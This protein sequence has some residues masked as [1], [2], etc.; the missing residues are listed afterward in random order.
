MSILLSGDYGIDISLKN[1]EN[2]KQISGSRIA[3]EAAM[4]PSCTVGVD[5]DAARC[6][7]GEK[8]YDHMA[9]H[10]RNNENGGI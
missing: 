1:C 9:E 2:R 7:S 8:R 10:I 5:A 3:S 4:L 6:S